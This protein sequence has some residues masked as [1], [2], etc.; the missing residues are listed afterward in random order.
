[1]LTANVENMLVTY[2]GRTLESGVV[3][4]KKISSESQLSPIVKSNLVEIRRIPL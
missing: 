2:I 1:M 4:R 3:H